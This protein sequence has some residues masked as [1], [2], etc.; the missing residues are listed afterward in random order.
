MAYLHLVRWINLLIIG[1]IFLLIKSQL[2][3]P[4]S[5]LSGVAICLTPFHWWLMALSTIF[6]AAS[7][8]VVNDIFDQD[9]DKLNR[10]KKMIVSNAISEKHAWNIYYVLVVLG[11]GMGVYLC[12][13]LG[14]ISNALLFFLSIG[15]LYFYSYSYKRQFLVGNLVVAFLAGLVLFLPIYFQQ[16]C[17]NIPWTKLPWTPILVALSFFSFLVTLMREIIKDMQDM[18]GDKRRHCRT[19]P[20]VLGIQGAK[21]VVTLLIFTLIFSV[22]WLQK[23]WLAQHDMVSFFYFLVAVQLPALLILYFVIK[24]KKPKEFHFPSTISKMLMLTGILYL[25]VFRITL[26]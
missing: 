3:D 23:S 8:N 4:V 15:G 10:P 22:G 12:H 16:M 26:Q 2:I 13:L 5:E 14:D 7:G 9:I 17:S 20:I 19:L 6:I 25:M 11:G 21:I 18:H 24:G 1:L